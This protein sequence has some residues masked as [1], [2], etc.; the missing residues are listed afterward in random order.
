MFV[1]EIMKYILYV[2]LWSK[3]NSSREQFVLFG[4]VFDKINFHVISS[5]FSASSL[6]PEGI[7]E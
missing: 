6:P 5:F 3:N 7:F 1:V 4:L 2:I